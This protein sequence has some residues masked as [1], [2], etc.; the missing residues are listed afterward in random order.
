[1]MVRGWQLTVSNLDVRY[2]Q[3]TDVLGFGSTEYSEDQLL[4]LSGVV[5]SRNTSEQIQYVDIKINIGHGRSSVTLSHFSC[6][7]EGVS[8]PWPSGQGPGSAATGLLELR[9]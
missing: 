9:V 7:T 2:I 5:L 8:I 3:I 1:M 4:V 6:V